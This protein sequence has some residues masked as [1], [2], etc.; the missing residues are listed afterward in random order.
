MQLAIRASPP[1]PPRIVADIRTGTGRRCHNL[2]QAVANEKRVID[3]APDAGEMV[4]DFQH[5]TPDLDDAPFAVGTNGTHIIQAVAP[6]EGETVL[7]KH[8]RTRSGTM[9]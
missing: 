6:V 1:F 3:A 8:Y 4:V 5:E 2:D 7:T 9:V